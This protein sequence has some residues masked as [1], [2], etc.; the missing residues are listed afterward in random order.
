M[1]TL[2]AAVTSKKVAAYEGVIE[3]Q[4]LRYSRLPDMQNEFDDFSNEG[5]IAVAKAIAKG[6]YPSLVVINGAM[7]NWARTRRR[8]N[9][10]QSP[11]ADE[12]LL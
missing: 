3:H 11:L 4:A 1:S 6:E 2:L 7:S 5:R 12:P 8:Q 9:A 10:G